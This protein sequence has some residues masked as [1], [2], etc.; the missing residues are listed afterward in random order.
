L[1]GNVLKK[2]ELAA[3]GWMAE[4]TS[5]TKPG[6]VSSALRI[7]PPISALASSNSTESP[8]CC[9]AMPA[10]SPFGPL[11]TT[12]ASKSVLST[13]NTFFCL[14]KIKTENHQRHSRDSIKADGL[15]H[16][17][18]GNEKSRHRT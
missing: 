7:P 12:T 2:G 10:A 13:I 4:Q 16:H 1:S 5:C 8:A 18:M 6:S 15:L 9:R 11:P 14:H 3:M 17:H